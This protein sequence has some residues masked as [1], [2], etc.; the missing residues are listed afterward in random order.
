[1]GL[2]FSNYVLVTNGFSDSK[3]LILTTT[4]TKCQSQKK[5]KRTQSAFFEQIRNRKKDI[6][7]IQ[8]KFNINSIQII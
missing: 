5:Q 2:M 4:V 7:H 8:R 3:N 1:M 6:C